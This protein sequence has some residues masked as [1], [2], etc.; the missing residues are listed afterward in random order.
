MGRQR[1][2]FHKYGNAG[3]LEETPY[4]LHTLIAEDST[5]LPPDRPV[6][7]LLAVRGLA[8]LCKLLTFGLPGAVEPTGTDVPASTALGII[9]ARKPDH[10]VK[11]AAVGRFLLDWVPVSSRLCVVRLATSVDISNGC[12]VP[13]CLFIVSTYAQTN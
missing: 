4:C 11:V 12:D 7:R 1:S 2:C 9:A 3:R 10:H 5:T 8:A 13:R 6:I